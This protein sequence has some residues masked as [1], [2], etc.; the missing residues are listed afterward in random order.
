MKKLA[1]LY[2]LP[3]EELLY[4]EKGANRH[5]ILIRAA[6]TV[7]L[8]YLAAQLASSVLLWGI[9]RWV[10]PPGIGGPGNLPVTDTI[11]PVLELRF[12]LLSLRER[13]STLSSGL[14]RIACLVLAGTDLLPGPPK[15][16]ALFKLRLFGV[17]LMGSALA[18]LPWML[19]DRIYRWGDYLILPMI[20]LAVAAVI[21]AVDLGLCSWLARKRDAR[22]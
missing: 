4:G 12:S 1:D 8:C 9:N 5:R 19:S 21:L 22:G 17:L 20:D 10:A 6:W 3:I 14:F 18:H 16:G 7:L 11:R 13:I 15:R 2:E